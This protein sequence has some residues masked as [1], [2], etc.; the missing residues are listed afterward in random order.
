MDSS[1]TTTTTATLSDTP[2]EE[3]S[4]AVKEG[5]PDQKNEESSTLPQGVEGNTTDQVEI[6]AKVATAEDAPEGDEQGDTQEKK[7]DTSAAG[8]Q[9]ADDDPKAAESSSKVEEEPS[10]PP[11]PRTRF[12]SVRVAWHRM[13]LGSN[14]GGRTA[15]PPVTLA[16]EEEGAERYETVDQFSETFHAN[17]QNNGRKK[18]MYRMSKVRRRDIALQHHTE[19]EIAQ[20]EQEV[21]TIRKDRA[22][23]S[24]ESEEESMK[25]MIARKKKEARGQKK[26]KRPG[27]LARFTRRRA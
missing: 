20:V 13:T 15:G 8:H 4:A 25:D 5:G 1:R 14:P 9:V 7:A 27:F 26:A 19:D 16:W 12:G 22:K 2:D 11:R 21:Q 18:T 10:A 24:Q 3:S 23:S 17:Q 6:S